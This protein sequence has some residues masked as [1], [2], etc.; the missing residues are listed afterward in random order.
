MNG[1]HLVH[2]RAIRI[3]TSFHAYV[4]SQIFLQIFPIIRGHDETLLNR[5][6]QSNLFLFYLI[7]EPNSLLCKRLHFRGEWT[8]K[9]MWMPEGSEMVSQSSHSGGIQVT[10]PFLVCW[11]KQLTIFFNFRL[12]IWL[13]KYLCNNWLYSLLFCNYIWFEEIPVSRG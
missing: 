3:N 6:D 4:K 12:F 5:T 2:Y 8:S 11:L 10:G 13:F 1:Y 7:N 9:T